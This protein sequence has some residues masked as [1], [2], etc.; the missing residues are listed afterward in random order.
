[1]SDPLERFADWWRAEQVP[2]VVATASPDGRPAARAVVLERFDERGFVFWSSSESRKGR[3]LAANPRAALVFVWSGRQ[4]RV[5]GAVEPV[6]PAENGAHWA[7]CEAKRQIAA[8][9]QDEPVG[10]RA[11]LEALV[12]AVPEDPPRP[13]F[14]IGYRVVP[15]LVELWE[16]RDDFVHD[17]FRYT[18][19]GAGGWTETRL[20][21]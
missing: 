11:E 3:D 5:E 20:Q 19:S 14:W 21:P 4:V 7:E 9:R 1:L 10:S 17:R 12:A 18:R 6:T 2:V 15:E 13:D 8:F 16:A